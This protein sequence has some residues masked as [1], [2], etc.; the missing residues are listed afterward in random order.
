VV[1][2]LAGPRAAGLLLVGEAL[3][4]GLKAADPIEIRGDRG[5]DSSGNLFP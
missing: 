5:G 1:D 2:P 3:D 4:F